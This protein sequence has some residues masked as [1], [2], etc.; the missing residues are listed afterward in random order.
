MSDKKSKES[1]S[2]RS[3]MIYTIVIL[4]VVAFIAGGG[5]IAGIEQF[6]T[7][8]NRDVI[9]NED[10]TIS[11]PSEAQVS[12]NKDKS[13]VYLAKVKDQKI[14]YGRD[15][16]FNRTL[17][18]YLNNPQI[19]L[20]ERITYAR[21]IFNQELN[22]IIGMFNARKMGIHISQQK[23]NQEV[24]KRYYSPDGAV[25]YEAMK[26]D[27]NRVNQ[28]SKK[29]M[30][31]LLYENYEFD[32]FNGLP[33]DEDEITY[34]YKLAEEKINVSYINISHDD[35]TNEVIENYF[36]ENKDKY[37]TFKMTKLIFNDESKE[38]AEKALTEILAEPERFIEIS[39]N[40][41]N[42]E[43][44][45]NL[46]YDTEYT[47]YN[48]LE[49]DEIK[50]LAVK[51]EEGKIGQHIVPINDIG[52]A[53]IRMDDKDY[54]NIFDS[55]VNYQVKKDY[56]TANLD[57]IKAAN[58]TKADSIYQMILT[59][60]ENGFANA[61]VSYQVEKEVAENVTF[62]SYGI[63]NVHPDSTDDLNFMVSLFKAEP[64]TVIPPYEYDNGFMIFKVGTKTQL[65]DEKKRFL[66]SIK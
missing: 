30:Q 51:T 54:G 49:N 34:K 62:M 65:N 45:I 27:L 3:L 64:E 4:I 53:I 35:V 42:E 20:Q 10:G 47:L 22:K 13:N 25:N 19:Q 9:E 41:T 26:D 44:A 32:Y 39:N 60:S 48:N 29:V 15:D 61:T 37:Q 57:S 7:S 8:L 14:V 52:Y 23:L 5:V 6:I 63:P 43:K 66:T 2:F 40:L 58:Q 12:Q 31:D 17:Q 50:A 33:I 11:I 16:T 24:G 59:D 56:V 38:E 1:F 21:F 28:L 46:I 18:Y 55:Q 36:T